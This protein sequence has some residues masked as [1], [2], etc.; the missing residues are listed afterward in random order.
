MSQVEHGRQAQ[1]ETRTRFAG[2]DHEPPAPAIDV[3][4]TVAH[5]HDLLMDGACADGRYT[6]QHIK[7]SACLQPSFVSRCAIV[8]LNWY[9]AIHGS[10]EEPWP[11]LQL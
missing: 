4:F 10:R 3:P 8:S 6:H 9:G 2:A 5:L 7:D 11:V 1:A